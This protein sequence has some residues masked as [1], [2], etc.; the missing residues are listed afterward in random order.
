MVLV[1]L[2]AYLLLHFK[3]TVLY[4]RA[5][6]NWPTPTMMIVLPDIL[7]DKMLGSLV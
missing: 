7:S 1:R 5:K 3:A 2:L 6:Y 4:K